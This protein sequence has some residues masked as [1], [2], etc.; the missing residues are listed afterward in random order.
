MRAP[1]KRFRKKAGQPARRWRPA[2]IALGCATLLAACAS[3]PERA[4]HRA[5]REYQRETQEAEQHAR[6]QLARLARAAQA[7]HA[8]NQ[9]WPGT[10]DEL[11][12]FAVR[13]RLDFDR[14]GFRR[15]D[16]AL[17]SDGTLQVYYVVD[18]SA[19][20]TPR[21]RFNLRGTLNVQPPAV[22]LQRR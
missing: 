17:L 18:S 13:E 10:L 1:L 3:P 21:H 19:F 2:W 7:F 4:M 12:R 22:E 14:F 5:M 15:A 6:E 16:F 20:D 11:A 9:Q 8:A